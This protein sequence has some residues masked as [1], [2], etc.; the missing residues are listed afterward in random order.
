MFGNKNVNDCE[1][2][3]SPRRMPCHDKYGDVGHRESVRLESACDFDGN[4]VMKGL[5]G[6]R[7]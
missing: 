3:R 7:F 1:L 5:I 6:R 2:Q 4:A